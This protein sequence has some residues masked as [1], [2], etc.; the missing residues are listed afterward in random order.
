[1]NQNIISN[2]PFFSAKADQRNKLMDSNVITYQRRDPIS[3]KY[4][5]LYII[6][7]SAAF[8]AI[9]LE[10]FIRKNFG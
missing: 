4:A 2:L 5:H 3:P 7:L 9:G 1:M 10:I 6:I 8:M